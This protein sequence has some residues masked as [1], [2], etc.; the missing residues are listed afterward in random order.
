MVTRSQ[1]PKT[2]HVVAEMPA[3]HRDWIVL[4]APLSDLSYS[5]ILQYIRHT[6]PW[7]KT[8]K[9]WSPWCAESSSHLFGRKRTP[10]RDMGHGSF[11]FKTTSPTTNN[12]VASTHSFHLST[13][14]SEKTSCATF[15]LLTKLDALDI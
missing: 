4:F 11:L 9:E 6:V 5:V 13:F 7:S 12:L 3:E 15:S 8:R 14:Q 2:G 1:H 10:Y